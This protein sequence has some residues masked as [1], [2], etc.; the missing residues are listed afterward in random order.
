MKMQDLSG[1]YSNFD[2]KAEER[3]RPNT[4]RPRSFYADEEEEF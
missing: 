1:K 4:Q 3:L 2:N